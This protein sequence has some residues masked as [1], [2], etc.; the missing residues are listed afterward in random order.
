MGRVSIVVI[1]HTCPAC[2]TPVHATCGE[3][4]EA[5]PIQWSTTCYPC[6]EKYGRTF[7]KPDDFTAYYSNLV[8]SYLPP[9][10][11]LQSNPAASLPPEGALSL[12][13]RKRKRKEQVQ[14]WTLEKCDILDS[15]TPVKLNKN[16]GETRLKS[17]GGVSINDLSCDDLKYFCAANKIV[18]YKSKTKLAIANMVVTHI[19]NHN[20]Y[21]NMAG[22]KSDIDKTPD[23]KSAKSKVKKGVNATIP[24]VV[25]MTGTYFRA[26][27][28]YF[29]QSTRPMVMTLGSQPTANELDQGCS[30]F[31]HEPVYEYLCQDYNADDEELDKLQYKHRIFNNEKPSQFD[32]LTTIDLANVLEYI[33][34]QYKKMKNSLSGDH[35]HFE[36]KVGEKVWLLYMHMAY[37][38]NGEIAALVIPSLSSAFGET[39]DRDDGDDDDVQNKLVG[40]KKRSPGRSTSKSHKIDTALED[41]SQVCNCALANRLARLVLTLSFH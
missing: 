33:K 39:M 12:A 6:Y 32:E 17:I 16:A 8:A 34:F 25:S 18:N 24:Q 7:S 27:N 10:G 3:V 9:A 26:I 36:N 38:D 21:D 2:N 20:C 31:L 1:K 35:V 28:V 41:I 14:T 22:T 29:R 37:K 11:A 23:D 40:T 5:A 4:D 13:E 19:V 30:K 15:L